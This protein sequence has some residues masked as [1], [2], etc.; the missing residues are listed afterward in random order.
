MSRVPRWRIGAAV[1]ILAGLVFLLGVFAPYYFCNLKLQSFVSDITR[2]VENQTK[3]DDVLRTWVVEKARQ[4]EL[5]ITEDE[6]HITHPQDGLRIDI[7]Y[8]VRVDLPGYTV[9]L[10]FYPGAGSR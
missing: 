4:L 10:H 1:L 2:R 6:V 7:R 8:F 3:S 9:N 5:P